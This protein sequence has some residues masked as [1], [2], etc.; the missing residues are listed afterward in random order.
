MEDKQALIKHIT[1]TAILKAI[2]PEAK[3]A[4]T[5]NCLG[6]E[7]IG[8][9]T[10]PFRMGRESRVGRIDGKLPVSEKAKA[11]KG[12][13]N[14]DIYLVDNGPSLQISRQHIKIERTQ[15]GYLLTDRESDC[16]TIVNDKK[17]GGEF[18]GG[19]C[20]LNDGDII[21]VGTEDSLYKF[22]FI[23]LI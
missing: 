13:P 23:S 10:F 4:I 7:I 8:I 3:S 22:E 12:K 15:T 6:D 11:K 5:K 17:I 2:T 16:G 14:N 1:P 19:T 20:E 18:T 21:T 9:W